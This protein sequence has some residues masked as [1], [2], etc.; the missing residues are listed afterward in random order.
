MHQLSPNWPTTMLASSSS[1]FISLLH[2]SFSR[3]NTLINIF[4][5]DTLSKILMLTRLGNGMNFMLRNYFWPKIGNT[6]GL[7][8]LAYFF[9]DYVYSIFKLSLM[10]T[11]WSYLFRKQLSEPEPDIWC[12]SPFLTSLHYVP[13]H[14]M[15][16]LQFLTE[17][18]INNKQMMEDR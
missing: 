9:N 15:Y 14:M 18:F 6:S 10:L 2:L 13:P 4:Y 1:Q 11:P 12:V 17:S 5:W 7:Y 3:K 8:Y 16:I